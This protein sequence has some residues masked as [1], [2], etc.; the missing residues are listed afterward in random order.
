MDRKCQPGA[1]S[2]VASAQPNWGKPDI[3]EGVTGK[4]KAK[5]VWEGSSGLSI[6]T[7]QELFSFN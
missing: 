4:E 7:I 6:F 2:I 1:V 3:R 5:T